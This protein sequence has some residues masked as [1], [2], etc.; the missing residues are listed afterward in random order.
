MNSI[1][2]IRMGLRNLWRRKLRTFLT[3]LGVLI[4]TSSIVVML[5]LGFG[6]QEAFKGQLARMGDLTTI[7]VHKGYGGGYMDSS[8]RNSDEVKLDDAAIESFKS[9][10]HVVTATPIV[11]TWGMMLSGKNMAH[12]T[13]KGIES[14]SMEY[15]EYKIAEGRLLES[16]DNLA[17]VF[18]GGM[19]YNFYNER[20]MRRGVYEPPEIDLMNDRMVFTFDTSAGYPPMPGEERPRYK[21]YNLKAVGVLQEGSWDTDY[22]VFMPIDTVQ[23]MLEEKE[24]A[25][26]NS[27]QNRS[28]GREYE[29]AL[30]KVDDVEN[31]QEVQQ[32]IKDTGY[33][34]YSLSDQ[35]NEIKKISNIIQ[36]VLGGIG[37]ISLLVAAIGITNTMVMSIY[38]RTKEIGIM[39]VIGASIKDIKKLFLFESALIGLL[40]GIFGVGMS[41]LLSL[42][43]NQ[44]GGGFLMNMGFEPGAKIS[45]IPVWL[46][47]AALGFS[48]L[49]GILSG[50]YPARRA[51]RLSALEAIR[52]E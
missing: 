8:R 48:A 51:M 3:V 27:Q 31:V 6:M 9:L 2:L 38:E 15:F 33:N 47:M 23:K 39:K 46:I 32:I 36:A 24:R 5:S 42:G 12:V 20:D 10:P 4:G 18:G 21:D 25:E 28:R 49:I 52:T 26:N 16:G 29:S 7:N 14:Q 50:Y 34:A 45:I 40:G 19:R 37:A 11:E 30:V 41:F 1:D 17:V 35:L 13:L 44:F 43:L 22:S